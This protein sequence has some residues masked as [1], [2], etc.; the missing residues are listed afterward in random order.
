M[1]FAILE[2]TGQ[3][4]CLHQ[5]NDRDLTA[6]KPQQLLPTLEHRRALRRNSEINGGV[7]I[8]L[9]TLVA[10]LRS[11]GESRR[12]T[13]QVAGALKHGKN[14]R[15]GAQIQPDFLG[16]IGGRFGE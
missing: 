11:A 4:R 15:E 13:P 1:N 5:F 14:V 12:G 2:W 16:V 10:A 7:E 3:H 6:H 9:H 8:E